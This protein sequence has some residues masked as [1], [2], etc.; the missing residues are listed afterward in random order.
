MSSRSSVFSLTVAATGI[1]AALGLW[2][3]AGKNA[4]EKTEATARAK[5]VEDLR[6]YIL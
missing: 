5:E 1:I 4:G 2:S 6:K 3:C